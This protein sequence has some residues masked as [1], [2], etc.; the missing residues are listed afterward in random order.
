MLKALEKKAGVD[1][2]R[3]P[4]MAAFR[5]WDF[6]GGRS[7]VDWSCRRP[8]LAVRHCGDGRSGRNLELTDLIQGYELRHPGL[9]SL[10]Q[11]QSA[12]GLLVAA[13]MFILSIKAY[14]RPFTFLEV[15]QYEINLR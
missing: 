14:C 6:A 9:G 2:G 12:N 15:T 4:G 7:G 11:M 10:Y 13:N 8:A 3:G 5:E 1:R